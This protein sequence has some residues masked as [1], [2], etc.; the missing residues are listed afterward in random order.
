MTT[1][2][3]KDLFLKNGDWQLFDEIMPDYNNDREVI[4]K[5]IQIEGRY[6][7]SASDSLK[8]DK[9]IVMMAVKKNG[10]AI[11]DINEKFWSDPDVIFAAKNTESGSYY[12]LIE[13]ID[14]KLFSDINF[15]KKLLNTVEDDSEEEVIEILE[16]AGKEVTSNKEIML[17]A[18]SANYESYNYLDESLKSDNQF[19][20]EAEKLSGYLLQYADKDLQ[21][22]RDVV[23]VAVETYGGEL[24]FAAEKFK[25]DREMVLKAVKTEP[26]ILEDVDEKFRSDFEIAKSAVTC[27]G[28][29]IKLLSEDLQ[30]NQEIKD[31]VEAW[32]I[33]FKKKQA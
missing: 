21:S 16:R 25:S 30:S 20:I 3:K 2:E 27:H 26:F 28:H 11:N 19:F 7:A 23:E 1:K 29:S 15:V 10:D 18:I 4:M 31:A 24:K 14:E 33:E 6:I 17:S 9:E 5:A 13:L 32:K 8:A 12:N 22:D